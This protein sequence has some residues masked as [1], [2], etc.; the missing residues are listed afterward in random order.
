MNKYTWLKCIEDVKLKQ[1]LELYNENKSNFK[2]LESDLEELKGC[3]EKMIFDLGIEIE[4][5]VKCNSRLYA[6]IFCKSLK[7]IESGS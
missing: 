6:E 4:K 1:M 7:E 3:Y 2:A 5:Y